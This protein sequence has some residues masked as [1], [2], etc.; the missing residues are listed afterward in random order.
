MPS[1]CSLRRLPS[2]YRGVA[3]QILSGGGGQSFVNELLHAVALRLTGDDIS[4]RIDVKAVQME[5]LARFPP[6][7]TDVADF[8]ERL[9]IENCNAL[10]RAVRDVDETLFRIGRQRN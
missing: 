5:E 1:L 10:V 4:L 7:P 8:F 9:A 3:S 2:E 6:G